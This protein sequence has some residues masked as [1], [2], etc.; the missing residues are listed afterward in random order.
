MCL[1]W[2]KRREGRY[3][4]LRFLKGVL[5]KDECGRIQIS[6]L[7]KEIMHIDYS[8]TVT[9]NRRHSLGCMAFRISIQLNDGFN[10]SSIF[11]GKNPREKRGDGNGPIPVKKQPN[12]LNYE[13]KNLH[14][15][16]QKRS[17]NKKSSLDQ[18]SILGE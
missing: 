14:P 2:R 4:Y 7:N 10:T 12:G 17:S 3:H 15:F 8:F 18:P 9:G 5:L 13:I 16:N 6:A 11:Q 1:D